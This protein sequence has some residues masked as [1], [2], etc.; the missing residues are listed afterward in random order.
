MYDTGSLVAQ[1]SS[2]SPAPLSPEPQYP[3]S[4]SLVKFHSLN[5]CFGAVFLSDLLLDG[6]EEFLG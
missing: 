4:R 6:L 2:A 1:L 5:L 3:Q